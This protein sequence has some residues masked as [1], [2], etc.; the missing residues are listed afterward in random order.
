MVVGEGRREVVGAFEAILQH[1]WDFGI[2]FT[3][4]LEYAFGEVCQVIGCGVRES[5]WGSKGSRIVIVDGF[6]DGGDG[7][8][9]RETGRLDEG[10]D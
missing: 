6:V 1:D 2:D 10:D 9:G 7:E 3:H 8:M 4:A 5:V